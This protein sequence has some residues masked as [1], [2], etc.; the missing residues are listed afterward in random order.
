MK[1]SYPFS[2]TLTLPIITA[3][4]LSACDPQQSTNADKLSFK[5]D[6]EVT[7]SD[8]AYGCESQVSFANAVEHYARKE[9][10]AWAEVIGRGPSCFGMTDRNGRQSSY[11]WTVLQIRGDLAQVGFTNSAQVS[12]NHA[13]YGHQYW[14]LTKWIVGNH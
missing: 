2:F 13:Y 6:D 5:A 8:S 10:A 14:T 1:H 3:L 4:L 11:K 12:Q 7:L 9:Y